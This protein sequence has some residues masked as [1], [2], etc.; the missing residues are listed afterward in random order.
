MS[1]IRE[2][3]QEFIGNTKEAVKPKPMRVG[4]KI[5][6]VIKQFPE[7]QRRRAQ[8][9]ALGYLQKKNDNLDIEWH[10][11]HSQTDTCLC[12]WRRNSEG[13]R[14]DVEI[15]HMPALSTYT[16]TS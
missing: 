8:I 10:T 9:N 11:H 6:A 14:V 4:D 5:R 16:L 7:I 2:V 1:T 12:A 3:V 13:Y 15:L